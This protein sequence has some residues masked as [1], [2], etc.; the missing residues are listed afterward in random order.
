M[1]WTEIAVWTGSLAY[2]RNLSW[3]DNLDLYD[4]KVSWDVGRAVVLNAALLVSPPYF[5]NGGGDKNHNVSDP[6]PLVDNFFVFNSFDVTICSNDQQGLSPH[7]YCRPT[8]FFLLTFCRPGECNDENSCLRLEGVL[9]C[10]GSLTS[11]AGK[12]AAW[13]RLYSEAA[14]TENSCLSNSPF[15]RTSLTCTVLKKFCPAQLIL[16]TPCT[17][18]CDVL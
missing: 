13:S 10:K 3:D 9:V 16:I 2:Y 7:M 6:F 18:W 5:W 8:V 1:S 15:Y 17:P 14:K 11:S 4:L 12:T